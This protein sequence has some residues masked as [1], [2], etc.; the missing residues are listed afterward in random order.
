V[1][2]ATVLPFE[3]SRRRP[4]HATISSGHARGKIVVKITR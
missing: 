3:A 2:V 4:C 1:D